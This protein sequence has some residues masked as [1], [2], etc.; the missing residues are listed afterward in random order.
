MTHSNSRAAY[1]SCRLSRIASALHRIKKFLK[2]TCESVS[3]HSQISP[4][5]SVYSFAVIL[6]YHTLAGT[7]R[8]DDPQKHG[9]GSVAVGVG[10]GGG[11]GGLTGGPVP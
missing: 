11:G 6:R 4:E 10:G 5:S 3:R 2:K 1:T 7:E 8:R 9:G